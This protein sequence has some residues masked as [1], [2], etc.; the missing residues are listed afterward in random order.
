MTG[1]YFGI[2]PHWLAPLDLT[3][4]E[5]RVLLAIAR[6]ASKARKEPRPGVIEMR[7][8]RVGTQSIADETNIDRRHVHAVILQ[9]E[10]KGILE[11][12]R[13]GGRERGST[14]GN[15]T[16][17]RVIFKRGADAVNCTKDGALSDAVNCTIHG[18]DT[19]PSTGLNCTV[20][21][22]RTESEQKE[23]TEPPTGEPRARP[24][25]GEIFSNDGGGEEVADRRQASLL[26]PILGSGDRT[27]V[28]K[29]YNPSPA[30]IELA[31]AFGFNA[32]AEDILGRWQRHRIANNRLPL[33][34][35]A[36]EADFE[37]WIRDQPRFEAERAARD[38]ER[39]GR[40]QRSTSTQAQD[41][42]AD[43]AFD[44]LRAL[45]AQRGANGR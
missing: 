16:E 28:I 1:P 20:H 19:A 30:L 44:K 31:A 3:G 23:R 36:A 9:L 6:H 42:A 18:Y 25:E 27:A 15:M 41:E 2:I 34:D 29:R 37:N 32:H 24:R 5:F 39:P 13:G 26:L 11:L 43:R 35:A 45:R 10:A 7:I 12:L 40:R 38:A 33:D 14:Q 17:Y 4:R 8:A 21:G 22:A